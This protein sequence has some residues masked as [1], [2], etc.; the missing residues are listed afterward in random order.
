MST[1]TAS[2]NFTQKEKKEQ[3]RLPTRS[4]AEAAAQKAAE[5]RQGKILY[6]AVIN[7]R[8]AQVYLT[9]KEIERLKG[10]PYICTEKNTYYGGNNLP[11]S[12]RT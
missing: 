9:P 1:K 4:D 11:K 5:R 8:P 7:G 2:T 12:K 3:K 6:H 10:E